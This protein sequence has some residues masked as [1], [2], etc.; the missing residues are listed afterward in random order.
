MITILISAIIKN[1]LLFYKKI[2]KDGVLSED[3]SVK[4]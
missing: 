1:Q 2:K 3:C 4:R